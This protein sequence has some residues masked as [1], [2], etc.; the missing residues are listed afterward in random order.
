MMS[1]FRLDFRRELCLISIM[2]H[3]IRNRDVPL[4]FFARVLLFVKVNR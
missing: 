1:S 2:K 3:Q 4:V